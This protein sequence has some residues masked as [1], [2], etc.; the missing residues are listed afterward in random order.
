MSLLRKLTLM[1]AEVSYQ[2]SGTTCTPRALDISNSKIQRFRDFGVLGP[3][4]KRIEHFIPYSSEI[5]G[6]GYSENH[7]R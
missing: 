2:L 6:M 5:A 4:P 7:L 3:T 1:E